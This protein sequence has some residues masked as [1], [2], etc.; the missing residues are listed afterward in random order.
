MR[1]PT[2]LDWVRRL[3]AI[4]R[5]GDH[6]AASEYD[7][8]RYAEVLEIAAQMAAAGSGAP[9]EVIKDLFSSA[10][11]YATPLIDVRGAVI[12]DGRI[13]LVKERSDGRWALPG[14]WADVGESPSVGIEREVREESGYEVRAVK[15]AALFDRNRHGHPPALFHAW[16]AFFLCEL[17]G[18][19]AKPSLETEAAEFF[20]PDELPPLSTGRT[21]ESQIL[22]MFEHHQDPG[23]PTSFD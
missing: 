20:R 2:W 9:I 4:A 16:R 13:L 19:S 10:D 15:L 5:T 23:R 14:G 7:R 11:G 17:L 6:Y 12:K 22:H 8:L 3:Q 21:T 18:G 1:D